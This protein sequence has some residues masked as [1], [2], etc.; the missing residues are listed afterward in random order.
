M[1]TSLKWLRLLC[2]LLVIPA[3]ARSAPVDSAFTYQGMLQSGGQPATGSFKFQFRLWS[4]AVDGTA[5]GAVLEQPAV[6][7]S[8]GV[9]TANLDFGSKAYNGEARWLEIA[10]QPGDGKGPLTLL[11]PRQPVSTVP[12][13]SYSLLAAKVPNSA[14]KAGSI[15]DGQVVRS[16]N[17]LKDDVNLIAGPNITLTTNANGLQIAAPGG[18]LALPYSGSDRTA[19]PL[20]ELANTGGGPVLKLTGTAGGGFPNAILHIDGGNG[21]RGLY[22]YDVTGDAILGDSWTGNAVSGYSGNTGV[23]IR[24]SSQNGTGTLGT[25]I[26]SGNYGSLGNAGYGVYGES[27]NG[28]GVVGVATHGNGVRGT[29]GDR[30]GVFGVS[31]TDVGVRGHS[32]GPDG[33]GVVGYATS[34]TGSARGVFGESDST[35]GIGVDA[36]NA[37]G[38]ALRAVS[39]ARFRDGATFEAKNGYGDHGDGTTGIAGRFESTYGTGVESIGGGIY[40]GGR[41]YNLQAGGSAVVAIANHDDAKNDYRGDA[42]RAYGNVYIDGDVGVSSDLLPAVGRTLSIAN[43]KCAKLLAGLKLFRIDHPLDPANQYLSHASVESS[44]VKN[45]YDGIVVTDG[46]GEATVE[47]P[48]WFEA[49]NENFRYQLTCLGQFAQVMVATELADRHFTIKTDKPNVKV[50]WQVTGNRHDAWI[51]AHPLVVEENKPAAEH[52]RYLA[53]EVFGAAKELRIGYRPPLNRAD[54]AK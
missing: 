9:F 48:A 23:A 22:A 17:S 2:L 31:D 26:A 29:S 45:L 4:A 24:G 41:F 32:A 35:T 53:P 20:F 51:K 27:G 18:G 12:Y 52:G 10:V 49:L 1:T 47:L 46:N 6:T 54:P 15:A 25:H 21:N 7:V 34:K 28:E 42:L 14:I 39:N 44:E 38:T 11:T 33:L 19:G 43:I 30:P 5:V 40:P 37:S 13:A 50:S 8:N 3:T 16:L 36:Y